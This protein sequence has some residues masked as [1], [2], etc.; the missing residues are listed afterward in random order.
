M[1]IENVRLFH[2]KSLAVQGTQSGKTSGILVIKLIWGRD[3]THV[4]EKQNSPWLK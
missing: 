2:E 3:S 4:A 1:L